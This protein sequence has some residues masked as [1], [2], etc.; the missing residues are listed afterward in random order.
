MHVQS[1]H[2][3]LIH[4]RSKQ[5]FGHAYM[6]EVCLAIGRANG[7]VCLAQLAD[8]AGVS[9]SLYSAPLSRLVRLGLIADARQEGDDYRSRWYTPTPTGSSLW[10][11]AEEITADLHE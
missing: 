4:K 10:L 7:R 6:L 8:A 2:A 5:L 3:G 1:G 11:I 9:R